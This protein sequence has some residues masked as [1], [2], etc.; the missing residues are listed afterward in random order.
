MLLLVP[1]TF[2]MHAFWAGHD[3]PAAQVQMVMFMKNLALLGGAMLP[4]HFGAG[5]HSLDARRDGPG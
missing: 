5:P 2:T 4:I 1:V 3:A